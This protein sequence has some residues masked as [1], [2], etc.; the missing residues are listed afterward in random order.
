MVRGADRTTD[1]VEECTRGKAVPSP[2]DPPVVRRVVKLWLSGE[3]VLIFC[4]YRETAKALRQHIAREVERATL[5]LAAEKLGSPD[6]QHLK[7]WF[8]R[9]ARRL[10]DEDSPFYKAIATTLRRPLEA[11]EFQILTPR[12]DELVQLLAAYVRSPSF[13]A[14]YLPLDIPEIR[15]ALSE[16]AGRG[17]VVREGA[18]TLARALT[19]RTDASDVSMTGRVQEFLR[20]AKE[21]EERGQQQIDLEDEGRSEP[22]TEYLKAI[23]VQTRG[24]EDEEAVGTDVATFRVQQPVRMVYGETKRE[25]R[26]RLMLAF[27]SPMFPEIL[28]SSAVLGEGVDLHRFCRYVIHH[29]LSWNPSTIEQRTGRLDGFDARPR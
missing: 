28:I 15:E 11:K 9:V 27:N 4:F 19:E 10:S 23:A 21:L 17:D 13:I 18:E 14:R 7:G 1:P 24:D 2:E 22:L 12:A 20:F 8:E 6:T 29:D 5:A 3:K 16:G 25:T 26:E